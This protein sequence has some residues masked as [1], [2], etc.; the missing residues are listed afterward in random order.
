[1]VSPSKGINV[2]YGHQ[3]APQEV[4]RINKQGMTTQ[5][6][7]ALLAQDL[8]AAREKVYSYIRKKYKVNLQLTPQ[9]EQ[10]LIDYAFNL[11]SLQAFPLMV[12]AVLQ[13]DK[14]GMKRE[15]KRSGV[16]SG[17]RQELTKRNNA[18][19]KFSGIAERFVYT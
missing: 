10:M 5:E 1:M 16:I 18:F 9:Q 3:L 14:E 4:E 19:A 8:V 12:D 15:Y 17:K 13:H 2:G 6:V 11:G 7:E